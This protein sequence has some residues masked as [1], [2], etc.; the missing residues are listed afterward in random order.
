MSISPNSIA[1]DK[2][3]ESD[4]RYYGWR[5]ALAANLGVMAGFGSLFVYTF[6]VFL[7]PLDAQFGWSREAISTAF[8]LGAITVGICSPGIGRLLDCFSPR[9]IILPC[10]AIFGVGFA[11]L[12]LLRPHLWQLYGTCILLGVVGN[13]AAQLAYSRAI[14][15]WFH[16]YLGMAF[17]AVMTGSAIGSMVLPILT[18]TFISHWGWRAAYLG[19]GALALALGLPL[20]WRF[21][22]ERENGRVEP[23]HPKKLAGVSWQQ[24]VHSLPFWIIIATLLLVSAS[25]NG[26]IAHLSAMMTDRHMTPEGAAFTLSVLGGASLGGRILV[27]R[28][29]DR[30][31]A[32]RVAFVMLLPS[33]VGIFILSRA[34]TLPAGCLATALIGI[35]GG[36]EADVIPYLLT[37]YFGLRAFS[38][39]YGLTWTFYAFA[40]AAGPIILGRAFDLT[41]SYTSTLTVF[42]AAVALG[43]SMMLLLPG[44]PTLPGTMSRHDMSS[45]L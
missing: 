20:S 12:A 43:A 32:S 30:F 18:Q 23:N 24:G 3:D 17:A 21:V 5:V 27:G 38:T 22:H 6:S 35:G 11:S 33:A 36:A 4:F 45:L 31:V 44:Y 1:Q 41:G 28:L 9:R 37:R 29:L 2:P 34:A 7:K 8:G 16:D 40:G 13:G 26:V 10:M 14:V 42:A 39:L 15:T 19:L 25:E